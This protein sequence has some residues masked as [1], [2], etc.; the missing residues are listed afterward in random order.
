MPTI[1]NITTSSKSD[2]KF[3]LK[4]LIEHFNLD[5]DVNTVNE[6]K[7]MSWLKYQI[8]VYQILEHIP[9]RPEISKSEYFDRIGQQN[10]SKLFL[11]I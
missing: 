2:E 7:I 1:N 5:I 8:G 9:N 3:L 10:N 11:N 4:S 6:A